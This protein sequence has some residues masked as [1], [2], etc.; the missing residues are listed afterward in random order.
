MNVPIVVLNDLN[1]LQLCLNTPLRT[2]FKIIY[3]L[4]N[5]KTIV[6]KWNTSLN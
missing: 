2:Q 4:I 5:L 1:E 3:I 6:K